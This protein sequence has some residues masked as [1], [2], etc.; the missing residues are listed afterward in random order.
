MLV[1]G[2]GKSGK[3]KCSRG[4]SN[5]RVRTRSGF[6]AAAALASGR[7]PLADTLNG[8]AF[9]N[10]G[11]QMANSGEKKNDKEEKEEREGG[12]VSHRSQPRQP[13]G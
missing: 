6:D 10:A 1:A 2:V 13:T 7:A 5:A 8:W 3:W 4:S 12:F 9:G 11:L